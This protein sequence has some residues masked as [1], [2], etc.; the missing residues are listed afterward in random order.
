MN[1]LTMLEFRD[2]LLLLLCMLAPL[3]YYLASKSQGYIKFSS[4]MG[5]NN[6]QKSQPLE[7][8]LR[9]RLL[10]VPPLLFS[11]AALSFA[12][13]AAGPRAG[14][15]NTRI[16][17]EGIS[18]M[19]VIDTS[20][21]M[22]ALDLSDDQEETRLDVVKRVFETF[23]MGKGALSGRKNDS[24]GIVRFAGYADTTYPL[25]LDHSGLI[26][27][28]RTL[29]IVSTQNEDGTAIG[30]ALM[31]AIS[32]ISESKSHSKVIIL[33]TDGENTAGEED[34]LQAAKLARSE[35]V[36]IYTVGAGS[37]NIAPVRITD[38]FT[39]QS[40]LYSIPVR[41]DEDLLEEIAK[42][43]DGTY[44]RATN[45]DGLKQIYEAIDKLEKTEMEQ[46]LYRQYNEYYSHFLLFGLLMCCAAF[47]GDATYFR[48]SP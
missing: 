28:V 5:L 47:L 14:V 18:I 29:E 36:K 21:S 23:V 12:F 25:T 9:Q 20:S 27:V 24:I 16:K 4:L 6:Q 10:F 38:P 26:G 35:G 1:A 32:R 30:D 2:P 22:L 48:R 40:T 8:S 31:L 11:I 17:K 43:T 3:A 42:I 15:K 7:T 46:T 19:M 13:A 44:F 34:P 33:L 37:N 45:E 39:G 41:I